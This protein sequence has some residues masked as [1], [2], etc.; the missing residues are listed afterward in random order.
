VKVLD[1]GIAALAGQN[2]FDT[3]GRLW[4]T[5][6][7]LAPEQLRGEPTYPAAD[8]YALGLLL[9]ECLTGTRAWPGGTVGEILA[10]RYQRRTP[11][12]PGIA[13][14]PREIIRLYEACVA[15][16]PNRRPPAAE[17]AA[18]LRRAA[19]TAPTVRPAAVLT[20]TIPPVPRTRSRRRAAVTASIAVAAAFV[21][22]IGLQIAN[23]YSTPGG[24]Q[25]DAAVDGAPAT[26]TPRPV[27]KPSPT[28][29]RPVRD[30]PVDDDRP[31]RRITDAWTPEA[32]SAPRRPKP[33][34]RPSSEA[35]TAAPTTP[36]TGSSPTDPPPTSTK[37]DPEQPTEPPATTAP[38]PEST[39]PPPEPDPEDPP[40]PDEDPAQEI[41]LADFQAADRH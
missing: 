32:T 9:F 26:L 38:P 3:H 19:G 33:T 15:D 30:V 21:S 10:A 25:A 4:G 1:F 6:A 22:I 36:P 39:D 28:S 8:V 35:P 20:R 16:D 13:G 27:T 29:T 5:P 14:L 34:P 24:R 7:H 11:R 17:V 31:G 40:P 23:G 37:P 41:V 18:T 12:L 2:S